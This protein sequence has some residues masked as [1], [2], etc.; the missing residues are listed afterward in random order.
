[1]FHTLSLTCGFFNDF[2]EVTYIFS[3]WWN[4][5]LRHACSMPIGV[6]S[7]CLATCMDALEVEERC[8]CLAGAV[9]EACQRCHC[10]TR[11]GDFT[12]IWHSFF[13][14]AGS[15]NDINVLQHSSVFASHV[16][17]HSPKVNFEIIDH[18]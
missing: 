8:I 5:R 10:H 9:Q 11:S 18:H 16:E 1:M 12:R 15:H 7:A 13:G 6:F 3:P 17:G 2:G 4:N 14:M